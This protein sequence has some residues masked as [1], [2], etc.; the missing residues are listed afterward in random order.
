[1]LPASAL[2]QALQTLDD[3]TSRVRLYRA[4][5]LRHLPTLTSAEGAWKGENRYTRPGLSHALYLG[6][7]PDLAMIEATQ[8]YQ[9]VFTT[10]PMP[11]FVIFPVEVRL[12]RVLDLTDPQVYPILHTSYTELTGDWRGDRLAGRVP[13]TWDLGEAAFKAGFEAI[14]YPSRYDGRRSNHVVFTER[15]APTQLNFDLDP[16]VEAF[17]AFQA[18]RAPHP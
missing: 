17:I 4:A 8:Q 13:P 2:P 9:A 5:Q 12:R 15:V 6:E 10:L 18:Q 11:A 1:M 7:A 14:K 16:V 3:T